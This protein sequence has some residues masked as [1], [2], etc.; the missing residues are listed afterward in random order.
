MRKSVSRGMVGKL[1]V[2]LAAGWLGC[3]GTA[4]QPPG[5][6]EL[7]DICLMPC[8]R[9]RY[10]AL[11]RLRWRGLRFIPPDCRKPCVRPLVSVYR[12]ATSRRGV[13]P[14]ACVSTATGKSID[15]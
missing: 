5:R 12:P 4:Y 13:I 10:G 1:S 2:L 3:G 11:A 9:Y 8:F 14:Q 15:V 7:H 6:W